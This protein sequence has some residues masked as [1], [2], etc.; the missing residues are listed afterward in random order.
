MSDIMALLKDALSTEVPDLD[1]ALDFDSNSVTPEAK[2]SDEIEKL[3]SQVE[4]LA[5]D[6][7]DAEKLATK[8]ESVEDVNPEDTESDDAESE[9]DTKVVD[10]GSKETEETEESEDSKDSD[11]PDDVT[12]EDLKTALIRKIVSSEDL[13]KQVAENMDNLEQPEPV[14]KAAETDE[15]DKIDETDK[16]DETDE[17]DKGGNE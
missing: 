17:T 10:S 1:K 9:K 15:T 12:P 2:P 6:L 11:V 16:T 3:A 8:P 4:Q 14:E 7:S 13:A 5:E